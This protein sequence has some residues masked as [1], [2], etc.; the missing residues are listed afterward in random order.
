MKLNF[1]HLDKVC[2]RI[3]SLLNSN[4][5]TFLTFFVVP[6]SEPRKFPKNGSP[7]GPQHINGGY[8]YPAKKTI[9]IY[10][11]EELPKV[12]LHETCHHLPL[13]TFHSWDHTSL[14]RIYSFFNIDKEGCSVSCTTNITPNE[15]IVEFWAEYFHCKF[16]SDEYNIPFIHLWE[17]EIRHALMKTK[18]VLQYQKKYYPLWKEDTHAYSYV[19]L[20]TILM[21]FWRE[22]IQIKIPYDVN[23]ISNF[24]M[25]H[26]QPM[27]QLVS[28]VKT[29]NTTDMR[30]TLL[31]DF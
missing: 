18:K 14:M 17:A 9:F 10:R 22:F 6:F 7:F 3:Q 28:Q 27:L 12:L 15:A 31:G 20:R 5:N 23:E 26:Y 1:H 24:F 30:M 25:K 8:T 4:V 16:L 2:K 19:V 13:D 29:K 11:Y 21:C